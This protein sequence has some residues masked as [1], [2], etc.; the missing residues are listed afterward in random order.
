MSNRC[1]CGT[2][3]WF[4]HTTT[5][6]NRSCGAGSQ[7]LPRRA[8][9]RHIFR[10]LNVIGCWVSVGTLCIVSPERRVVAAGPCSAGSQLLPVRA[11]GRPILRAIDF[12]GWWVCV[13]RRLSAS[14]RRSGELWPPDLEAQ[15]HNCCPGVQQGALFLGQSILLDGVWVLSS[16]ALHRNAAKAERCRCRTLRRR[17]TSALE[18]F[19]GGSESISPGQSILLDG[20]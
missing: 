5:Q 9:G 8:T 3:E 15:I 6:K 13:E 4:H 11:T 16:A 19:D 7:L 2:R 1:T 10:A 18:M 17:F 20:G 12:I 14:R